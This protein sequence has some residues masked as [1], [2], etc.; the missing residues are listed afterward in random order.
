MQV[1]GFN[2]TPLTI[3]GDTTLSVD[4]ALDTRNRV[5]V[6]LGA[7]RTGQSFSNVLLGFDRS[8]ARGGYLGCVDDLHMVSHRSRPYRVERVQFLL[9]DGP[10]VGHP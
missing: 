8:G 2:G 9:H 4:L 1:H 3:R 7:V 6:E 5:T 10:L